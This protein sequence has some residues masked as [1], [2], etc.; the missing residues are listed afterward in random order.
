[1]LSKGFGLNLNGGG[2]L[3]YAASIQ[4]KRVLQL[5]ADPLA[6]EALFMRQVGLLALPLKGGI[7]KNCMSV[8]LTLSQNTS[9][10]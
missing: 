5:R 7:T 6:L 10:P 4:F 2:V 3:C 8:T 1:M 9:S